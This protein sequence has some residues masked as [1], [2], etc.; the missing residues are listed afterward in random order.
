MIL[1]RVLAA[2][3][4]QFSAAQLSSLPKRPSNPYIHYVSANF[5]LV[6]SK[7]PPN[8]PG[9]DIMKSLGQA[10]SILPAGR[11][12]VYQQKALVE[13]KKYDNFFRTASLQ[14]LF[15]AEDKKEKKYM[16]KKFEELG[17]LPKRPPPSGYVLFISRQKGNP[18]LTA[19][20]NMKLFAQKYQKLS[21]DEKT[22][23]VDEVGV[24]KVAYENRMQQLLNP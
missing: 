11:K 6:K 4:P 15:E 19:P 18:K 17:R 3:C 14:L 22:R 9:K 5:P 2:V 24:M 20:E 7:H 12:T 10:W 23:L 16:M 1:S 8:T 21:A 13:T